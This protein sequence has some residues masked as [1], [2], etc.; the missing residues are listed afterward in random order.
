MSPLPSPYGPIP[1]LRPSVPS[2]ALCPLYGRLSPLRPSV[3]STALCLLYGPPSALRPSAPL[4]DML[5]PTVSWNQCV[6]SQHVSPKRAFS[7]NSETSRTTHFVSRNSEA[8]FVK[9]FRQIPYL[10]DSPVSLLAVSFRSSY[11]SACLYLVLTSLPLVHYLVVVACRLHSF[12]S[13]SA[14][15]I[16]ILPLTCSVLFL[17]KYFLAHFCFRNQ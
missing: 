7:R 12:S 14:V 17:S 10:S 8:R 5:L 3:S 6:V 2:T 11:G 4:R 13:I 16:E 15:C 1:P 9:Q